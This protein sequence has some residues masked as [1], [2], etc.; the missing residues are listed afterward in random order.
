MTISVDKKTFCAALERVC[1][2]APS[3]GTIPVLSHVSLSSEGERLFYRATNLAIALSGDIDC[4]GKPAA[5]TANARDLLA[6]ASSVIGETVKLTEKSGQLTIAGSGKRS[7]R[8]GALSAA[9]FPVLEPASP[10][11]VTVP[12]AA[13]CEVIER[14]MFAVAAETDERPHLRS[15][16]LRLRNGEISAA[17]AD[18]RAVAIA[19]RACES[20]TTFEALV[21]RGAIA[22]IVAFGF[23]SVE[24]GRTDAALLFRS[25]RETMQT[26]TIASEFPPVDMVV[27]NVRPTLHGDVNGPMVS[28]AVTAIRRANSSSDLVLGFGDGELKIECYGGAYA[29]DTVELNG[30]LKGE[31]GVSAN[32]LLGALKSCETAEIGIGGELD[33]LMITSAGLVAL[34]MPMKIEIVRGGGR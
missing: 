2:I 4:T 18:G 28:D 14:V 26:Q 11:W 30:S 1:K 23:E 7:F 13:L 6:A 27:A 3:K 15:V 8:M 9:D 31:L 29:V 24:M 16:R 34:I 25:G 20:A 21:P 22:S 17:G 32:Y 12:S 33:P 19:T 10:E 5:F